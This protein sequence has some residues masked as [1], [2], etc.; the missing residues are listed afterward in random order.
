M[1]ISKTAPLAPPQL[2]TSPFIR[3]EIFV[4][5]AFGRLMCLSHV[6]PKV[7][8][9]SDDLL[10]SKAGPIRLRPVALA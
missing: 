9:L 7:C 6:Q 2:P 8:P 5:E 3:T 1:E 10:I 4:D